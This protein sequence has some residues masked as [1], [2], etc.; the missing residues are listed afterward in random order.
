MQLQGKT[1]LVTGSSSGIGRST[2]IA[3]A[4]AGVTVFVHY[5]KNEAGAQE[6]LKEIEKHSSG[7]IYTA[8]L[9]K[10][11]D[12]AILF[13]SLPTQPEILV[14]NAGEATPG[15]LENWET[16]Q[17]QWENI[18]MSQVRI[19][20]QFL[21]KDN[22]E[23]RKIVNVSSVYGILET[24][25]PE[26]M[27]YSAAKAALNSFTLNL[28]KEWAS[29][30][31]VNAVAPGYTWTEAWEGTPDQELET[32]KDLTKIKR[33]IQP[34]EIASAILFLLE[35]DAVTGEILRVDG[36]LHLANV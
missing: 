9:T 1:A 15:A 32:C 17:H 26:F 34:E 22:S 18:F 24:G 12:I 30:V 6:T 23:L 2:A 29:S 11:K 8:D 5:R 25:S 28:A 27:Q 33:F 21:K 3:L 31:L 14:N 13:E 20:E 19:A 16:W 4:Q 36:G 35:N 10:E 7:S